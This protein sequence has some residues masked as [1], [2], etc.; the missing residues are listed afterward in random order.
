MMLN[1]IEIVKLSSEDASAVA[2]LHISGIKTGFISSLGTEFVTALYEAIAECESGF[3]YVAKKDGHVLGYSCFTTDLSSLYKTVILSNGFKLVFRLARKMFSLKTIKKIFETLFY[4]SRISKLNLPSA[5]FLS[6][7]IAE[8]GRGQGLA[9]KLMQMGFDECSR[10]GFEKIKIFAAVDIK[11][12]NK[13][14]KKY[15]FELVEQ[16]DNHGIVSNIYVA[17]TGVNYIGT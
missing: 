15:G 9:S 6:M 17:D 3:G 4:P 13:M 2:A 5:E 10:R 14:Y 7:V 11:P 1:D 16:M 12:I 8:K